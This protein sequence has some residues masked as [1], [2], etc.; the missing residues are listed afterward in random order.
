[1]PLPNAVRSS[2]SAGQVYLGGSYI[3]LGINRNGYFGT[4]GANPAG[5]TGRR[6]GSG[7]GLVGDADGFGIGKI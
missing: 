4:S 2:T 1:M 3:E 7:I 5:F 6:T